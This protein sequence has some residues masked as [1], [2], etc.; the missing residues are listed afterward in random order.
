MIRTKPPIF[1][2]ITPV[3]STGM[4]AVDLGEMDESFEGP[5]HSSLPPVTTPVTETHRQTDNT[6][7]GRH[8]SLPP[9]IMAMEPAHPVSAVEDSDTGGETD[10]SANSVLSGE[11]GP[12]PRKGDNRPKVSY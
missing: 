6:R 12:S 1:F 5:R 2:N 8:R 4:T 11:T 9:K 7:G 10:D 3:N